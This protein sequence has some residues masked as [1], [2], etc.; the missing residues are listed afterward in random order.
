MQLPELLKLNNGHEVENIND[1]LVRRAEIIDILTNECYGELIPAPEK[2]EVMPIH[3]IRL[4][5]TKSTVMGEIYD[6]IMPDLPFT[7]RFTLFLPQADI[8]GK[9]PVIIDGDQGWLNITHEIIDEITANGIAL[10]LFDRLDIVP[11]NGSSDRSHGLYK[12]YPDIDFYALMAW[13]WGYSRIIDALE[14]RTD[15]IDTAK[16]AVTGHSRGGKAAMLAGALDERVWLTNPNNSGLG[17][18]GC[19]N[20]PDDG[21]E[22]LENILGAFPYW[23]SPNMKKYIGKE[24]E[25]PFDLHFLKALIAP[26]LLLTTEGLDDTWASPKATKMTLEAAMPSFELYGKKENACMVYRE[27][28]HGHLLEDFSS[29]TSYITERLT[30]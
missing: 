3:N 18:A 9:Y 22:R 28:G 6:I 20:Y 27:G 19:I 15:N 11:D 24:G 29:L 4:Y 17:G 30:A 12:I 5:G 2:I 13:S 16:I 10:A 25:V 8:Y 26:R 7:L 21:G 1:W 14:L 23:F